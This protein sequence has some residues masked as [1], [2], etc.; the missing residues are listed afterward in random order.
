MNFDVGDRVWAWVP[1]GGYQQRY[2]GTV[3]EITSAITYAFWPY[4]VRLETGET[5][6]SRREHLTPL[7]FYPPKS[8]FAVADYVSRQRHLDTMNE[9]SDEDSWAWILT[10]LRRTREEVDLILEEYGR[11]EPRGDAS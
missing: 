8:K 1:E 6:P 11:A 2:L 3:V 9:L 5:I 7:E 10:F 4:H